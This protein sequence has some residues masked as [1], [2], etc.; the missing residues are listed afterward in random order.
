MASSFL[1]NLFVFFSIRT[2][3]P[4]TRGFQ[5]EIFF[6]D[7]FCLLFKYA[8]SF[9]NFYFMNR[10]ISFRLQNRYQKKAKQKLSCSRICCEKLRL[11]Y[12]IQRKV[13]D[14]V[15]INRTS[16]DTEFTIYIHIKQTKRNTSHWIIVVNPLV[17]MLSLSSW[18]Q[19]E[20]R[21]IKFNISPRKYTLPC[22]L[23]WISYAR[24][25]KTFKKS[26]KWVF[27]N[28]TNNF[29]TKNELPAWNNLKNLIK[30]YSRLDSICWSLL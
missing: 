4:I 6:L 24:E 29:R 22:W 28:F 16:T 20:H 21:Q 2:W 19:C 14:Q 8:I 11:V 10:K 25:S 30:K 13:T 26:S 17:R 12:E 15:R 27:Q 9:M 23:G 5:L 1:N 7:D 3:S 18:K